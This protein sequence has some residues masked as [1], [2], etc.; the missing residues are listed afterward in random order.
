MKGTSSLS[1]MQRIAIAGVWYNAS[2]SMGC[3][4]GPLLS[5]I[6]AETMTF[7]QTLLVLLPP[8]LSVQ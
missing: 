7:D 8:C 1:N 4:V 6:L 5:G 3:T 2:Y